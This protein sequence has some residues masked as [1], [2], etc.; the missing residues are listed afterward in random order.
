MNLKV[1]LPNGRV[2]IAPYISQIE[3]PIGYR[4][5]VSAEHRQTTGI[6]VG[7]SEKD[8]SANNVEFLDKYPI[9]TPQH[10]KTVLDISNFY[11]L[12]PWNFLFDLLPKAFQW[13]KEK[14]IRLSRHL[15]KTLD[16]Q[17]L[18]VLL[19]VQRRKELK[20]ELLKKHFGKEKVEILK[21]KGFLESFYKWDMPK[22]EVEILKLG[23]SYAEAIE[24]IKK[25]KN[26][27]EKLALIN[28]ISERLYCTTDELKSEGFKTK[29]IKDLAKVGVIQKEK[30]YVYGIKNI[31][32]TV[33]QEKPNLIKA[34]QKS[35]IILGYRDDLIRRLL[36]LLEL[37]L[38]RRKSSLIFVSSLSNL[39]SLESILTDTFG[40]KVIF[41]SSKESPKSLVKAWFLS[42]EEPRIVIGTNLVALTPIKDVETVI[43]F[44]EFEAKLYNGV[45]LRNY[46]YTLSKYLGAKFVLF[47]PSP[48]THTYRAIKDGILD[49]EV[50]DYPAKVVLIQ[51]KPREIITSQVL[52]ILKDTSKETLVLVNKLGYAYAFCPSCQDLLFCPNC[53]SLLTLTASQE[54]VFCKCGY[55]S[56]ALCPIHEVKLEPWGFGIE[57][58]IEEVETK[59]G[60]LNHIHYAPQP[61]LSRT[62]HHTVVINADNILNVPFF[63][64][65]ER[66]FKYLWT[67][68]SITKEKLIVQTLQPDF[69]VLQSLV[70]KNPF[71]FLESELKERQEE[72]LPPFAKIVLA[73]YT[74]KGKLALEELK[75]LCIN[76]RLYEKDNSW[77]LFCKTTSKNLGNLLRVIRKENPI[78]V[79]VI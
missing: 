43:V 47:T 48:D 20:E 75:A 50:L 46:F 32:Y 76:F 54:E 58:V 72:N 6:V 11:G 24:R 13:K 52:E 33:N 77:E 41:I 66:Y 67:A 70:E 63:D 60:K 36:E 42:F 26:K 37:S 16:K 56:Q 53:S 27:E 78:K 64:S 3:N 21:K 12:L 39:A 62:Y 4:V 17:S 79:S 71:D 49:K 31:P 61:N 9:T 2:L 7:I 23:V 38:Q 40:D 5:L 30:E 73:K 10:I 69:P 19:Y 65:Q 22:L 57:K 15:D 55:R 68:L 1:A 59:L 44:D 29:D 8:A 74:K 18:E 45:D 34:L 14:F 51:R 35:S 28:Y 25:F